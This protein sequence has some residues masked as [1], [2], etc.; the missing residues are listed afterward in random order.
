MPRQ[1]LGHLMNSVSTSMIVLTTSFV[2][3]RF[4]SR[5]VSKTGIGWD[6]WLALAS[7]V[8]KALH[9]AEIGQH[10]DSI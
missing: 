10:A 3:L 1:D 8:N 6:D 7:L 9:S 4:F 5:K 2:A